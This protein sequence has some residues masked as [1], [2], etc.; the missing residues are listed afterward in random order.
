MLGDRLIQST[1]H[2]ASYISRVPCIFRISI[3]GIEGEKEAFRK[4]SILND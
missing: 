4:M 2:F 3:K 1:L